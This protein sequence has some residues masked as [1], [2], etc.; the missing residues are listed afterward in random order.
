MLRS[1]IE[2]FKSNVTMLDAYM[3]ATGIHVREN[4]N[5]DIQVRCFLH[6]S[7]KKPSARIYKTG[8][9]YCFTCK[10]T[11][12]PYTYIMT[13]RG[14]TYKE[15]SSQFKLLDELELAF[16]ISELELP[17]FEHATEEDC[18]KK[19]VIIENDKYKSWFEDKWVFLNDCGIRMNGSDRAEWV[20]TGIEK[21]LC[22]A[23]KTRDF[24]KAWEYLNEI[25]KRVNYDNNI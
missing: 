25:E 19:E 11:Y 3:Y 21:C 20:F 16:N 5:G 6:G 13:H 10:R 15:V 2:R 22:F 9:F 24:K 23:L 4:Y 1:R 7:D 18:Q 17:V 14:I 8:N 12:D